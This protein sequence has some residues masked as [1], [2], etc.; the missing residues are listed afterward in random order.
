MNTIADPFNAIETNLLGGR[1]RLF[2]PAQGFRV[3]IDTV[4]LAAAVPAV[5]GDL[6][7]DVGSGN[8]AAA[9]CLCARVPGVRVWGLERQ[10]DLVTLAR[11][12]ATA[13]GLQ[14]NL[15]FFSGDLMYPP[16]NFTDVT[17]DHVLANP[18]YIKANSGQMPANPAKALAT[19]E[20]RAK[21]IDWLDFCLNMAT[22]TGTV[23]IVHRYDRLQEILDHLGK[24]Y[25]QTV[26]KPLIS[27]KGSNPKRVLVQMTK[28]HNGSILRV[29][30]LILHQ[31]DGKYTAAAEAVLRHAQPLYLSE[32]KNDKQKK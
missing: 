24:S 4:F 17:Y 21:L 20:G 7:L 16:D 30:S 1:V 14:D 32:P 3:G 29:P 31:R 26:I 10:N 9:L 28:G 8:G 12:S 22:P 15:D 5:N 13:N 23:T 2:Q 18:P 27:M 11:R 25:G 6:V 19:V